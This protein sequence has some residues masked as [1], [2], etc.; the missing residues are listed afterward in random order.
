MFMSM[1]DFDVA[2]V[3]IDQNAQ[4]GFFAGPRDESLIQLAESALGF[5]LPPTYRAF[6]LR[7]GAGNFGAAEFYGVINDNFDSGKVPNGISLTIKNRQ[8]NRI[9][10]EL[11]VVGSTGDGDYYCLE[12]T[13]GKEAPLIIYQPGYAQDKQRREEVAEDFGQFL[14]E[15]VKSEM[16]GR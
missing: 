12:I 7:F 6:V 9:P 10:K 13:P 14:L 2:A 11:I 4:R 8:E 3:S 5:S 1:S 16:S 15:Q